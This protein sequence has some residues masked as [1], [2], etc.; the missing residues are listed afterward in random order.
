MA[1]FL[2]VCGD[3]HK[4]KPICFHLLFLFLRL[5]TDIICSDTRQ[6]DFLH[7]VN[8]LRE[9]RIMYSPPSCN[10]TALHCTHLVG[11]PGHHIEVTFDPFPR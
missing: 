8:R 1:N 6:S 2:F 4:G 9:T 3:R 11:S 5:T 7:L 10:P